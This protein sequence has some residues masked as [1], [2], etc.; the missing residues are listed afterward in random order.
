ME[1]RLEP[2]TWPALFPDST[3]LFGLSIG[4][5]N[6]SG[7]PRG[8]DSPPTWGT[9]KQLHV[10]PGHLLELGGLGRPTAPRFRPSAALLR[11]P[12]LLVAAGPLLRSFGVSGGRWAPLGEPRLLPGAMLGL[13]SWEG[14]ARCWR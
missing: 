2:S 11:G 8:A 13:V 9:Q 4:L 5:S 10:T 14:Q 3:W 6:R 1:W 12:T 7:S